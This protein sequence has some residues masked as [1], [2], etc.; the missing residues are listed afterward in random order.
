[1]KLKYKN[2]LIIAAIAVVASFISI[3]A[4]ASEKTGEIVINLRENK[5]PLRDIPGTDTILHTFSMAYGSVIN[6]IENTNGTDKGVLTLLSELKDIDFYRIKDNDGIIGENDVVLIKINSKWA[7]RGGTNTDLLKNLIQFIVDHPSGFNGEIIIADNGQGMFGSEGNG[8]NFNWAASNAKDKSQS[9]QNVID[10]FARRNYKISSILWDN[11][12]KKKV[13]EFSSG[14]NNDGYV[15]ESGI[16]PTGIQI[17]YAKWTTKYGTQVSFKYGVWNH[18]SKTYD[19]KKLRVI[20]V[21]VLKSHQLFHVTGAVKSYMGIPS[22]ALTDLSPHKSVGF[23]G[24]GTLMVET[25]FPVLNILD[26]IY[27]C[28]QR[29]PASLY[30]T[31]VQKNIIAASTDPFALDWWAAKYIL[32]PAAESAGNVRA[33]LMD[34]DS[35]DT[36]SF[37][38]W[39]KKSLF[40]VKNAGIPATTEIDSIFIYNMNLKN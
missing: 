7:E 26:M 27:I 19:T 12:T 29:G 17:S 39:L 25:R 13:S 10:Y 2:F 6:V 34:P 40:E 20:N 11:I 4:S 35:K 37:G 31:A 38:Y 16:K 22:D 3:A 1:M 15:V 28:P 21:P 30:N 23:G 8:G 9:A 18:L 5:I 14:D 24:L 33:K 32:T 36:I